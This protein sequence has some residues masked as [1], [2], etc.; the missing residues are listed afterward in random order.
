MCDF[1][2]WLWSAVCCLLGYQA[3]KNM[4]DLGAGWREIL[5]FF[6]LVHLAL[7]GHLG[8]GV[9]CSRE[10]NIFPRGDYSGSNKRGGWHNPSN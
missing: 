10:S 6:F 8:A 1:V 5:E 9:K 3:W 7:K 4:G 2:L